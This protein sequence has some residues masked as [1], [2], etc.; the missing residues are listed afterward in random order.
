MQLLN[1]P[2]DEKGSV[3][4]LLPVEGLE[5]YRRRDD[6][7]WPFSVHITGIRSAVTHQHRYEWNALQGW[8]ARIQFQFQFQ[9]QSSFSFSFSFSSASLLR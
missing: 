4:T 5:S 6:P 7:R 9:F 2:R 1:T 3:R 8:G